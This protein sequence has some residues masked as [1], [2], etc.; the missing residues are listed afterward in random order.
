MNE[1]KKKDAALI[2]SRVFFPRITLGKGGPS[3]SQAVRMVVEEVRR[4]TLT[5]GRHYQMGLF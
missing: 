1:L 5:Q 3:F 4:G 2:K